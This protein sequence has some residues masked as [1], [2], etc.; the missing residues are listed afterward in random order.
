MVSIVFHGRF[1]HLAGINKIKLEI[2]PGLSIKSLINVILSKYPDLKSA[3][4]DDNDGYKLNPRLVILVDG[5]SIKLLNGL[6]TKL[7]TKD[8]VTFDRIDFISPVGGG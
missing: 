1:H 4:F 8:S 3:F 7:S 6:R 2:E 5:H